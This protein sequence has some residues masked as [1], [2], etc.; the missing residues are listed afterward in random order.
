MIKVKQVSFL[1]IAMAL[2]SAPE[3]FGM[4][5]LKKIWKKDTQKIDNLK[6]S[7]TQNIGTTLEGSMV[8]V[9][10]GNE[11]KNLV[12]EE[13]INQIPLDNN[14]LINNE[15]KVEPSNSF[16]AGGFPVSVFLPENE[17]KKVTENDS[18]YQKCLNNRE[19]YEQEYEE[20]EK[21]NK[22][23]EQENIDEQIL[24][25]ADN[26]KE[27]EKEDGKKKFIS[28]TTSSN[29]TTSEGSS[30]FKR[31]KT[32]MESYYGENDPETNIAKNM[33]NALKEEMKKNNGNS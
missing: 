23:L 25:L 20:Q 27:Y 16:T 13:N 11:I 21:K 8:L 12:K 7:D 28:S 14:F 5:Y 9:G 4:G 19:K 15:K 2:M 6:K 10:L 29:T 33:M 22:E 17:Q 3:A 31:K 32:P 1:C 24:N 26:K 30:C 18:T